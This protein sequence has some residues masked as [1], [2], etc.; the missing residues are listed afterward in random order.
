[1]EISFDPIEGT[2]HQF[3]CRHL[4]LKILPNFELLNSYFES[5]FLHFLLY[6]VLETF[7][8]IEHAAVADHCS[9]F[10]PHYLP[11]LLLGRLLLV[12]SLVLAEFVA[13]SAG[14]TR[15]ESFARTTFTSPFV[16][17]VVHVRVF[18]TAFEILRSMDGDIR[19][20]YAF[21]PCSFAFNFAVGSFEV[22]MIFVGVVAETF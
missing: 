12:H 14:P 20:V 16:G 19:E 5:L 15:N 3:P 21:A 18:A 6:T 22:V 7:S 13:A 9:S 10:H 17:I 4:F 1:M 8:S 11:L 2:I